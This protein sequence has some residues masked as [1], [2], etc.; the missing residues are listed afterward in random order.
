[1]TLIKIY[2]EKLL[3]SDDLEAERL[4]IRRQNEINLDG[5]YSKL[6]QLEKK[7]EEI[8]KDK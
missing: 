8:E 6:E 4:T 5:I 2:A 1:M 7:L 3:I